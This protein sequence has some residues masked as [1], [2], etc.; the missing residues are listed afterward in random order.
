M[1]H[2][3]EINLADVRLCNARRA[4]VGY[5]DFE[6]PYGMD[7][8]VDFSQ[9]GMQPRHFVRLCD[10]LGDKL[11][12]ALYTKVLPA[13][14]SV[15][16]LGN[17]YVK[18]R[19]LVCITL[20]GLPTLGRMRANS[21]HLVVLHG[22][23]PDNARYKIVMHHDNSGNKRQR[24]HEDENTVQIPKLVLPTVIGTP[25]RPVLKLSERLDS[26]GAR[27]HG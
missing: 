5:L 2:D 25:N 21:Q 14:M 9:T 24:L 26:G 3:I 22:A 12:V 19:N 20:G 27:P 17:I 13:E 8:F 4:P 18:K 1:H 11:Y 7:E 16:V 6:T 23:F 10:T 15:E